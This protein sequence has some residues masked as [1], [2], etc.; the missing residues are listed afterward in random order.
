VDSLSNERSDLKDKLGKCRAAEQK[1][2]NCLGEQ[3]VEF[4]AAMTKLQETTEQLQNN[5]DQAHADKEKLQHDL[6]QAHADKKKLEAYLERRKDKADEMSAEDLSLLS[7]LAGR[8]SGDAVP[9]PPPPP[10]FPQFGADRGTGAP[11]TGVGNVR[12]VTN[13]AGVNSAV[14]PVEADTDHTNAGNGTTPLVGP[15]DTPANFD[16]LLPLGYPKEGFDSKKG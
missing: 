2:L 7:G 1:T 6:D 15:E 13:A 11:P 4:K 9:S 16:E 3:E 5:L 10:P 12:L 8:S 14:A